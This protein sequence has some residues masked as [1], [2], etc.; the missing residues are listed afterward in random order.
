[1]CD[2]EEGIKSR[3]Q[4]EQRKAALS[5]LCHTQ[6]QYWTFS[7]N[8][9]QTMPPDRFFRTALLLLILLTC[10]ACSEQN[11][12]SDTSPPAPDVVTASFD[13]EALELPL[14]AQ[15]DRLAI[16]VSP[17]NADPDSLSWESL[18]PRVATIEAG[19]ITATGLGET[20]IR[21][22]NRDGIEL[23]SLE[24]TIRKTRIY[25]IGN[26]HTWDFAPSYDFRNLAAA[27]GVEIEN[28]WHIYCGHNIADILA[29]PENTCV[30]SRFGNFINALNSQQ[31]DIVTLQPF[32]GGTGQSE[33]NAIKQMIE[34]IE[35]NSTTLP[36][37]YIYYT[38]PYNGQSTLTDFDYAQAW[39]DPFNPG[40]RLNSLNGNFI[41]YLRTELE[42]DDYPISGYIP[43]GTI[44]EEFHHAAQAGQI[45]GFSGAGELYRDALHMNNVGRFLAGTT[46]FASLFG[47]DTLHPFNHAG[48]NPSPRWASD[49]LLSSE[50]RNML[51]EL[52]RRA[53][54]GS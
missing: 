48:Y 36:Q 31:W 28:D 26:S 25:S 45:T 9:P 39:Q 10:H 30:P 51:L 35:A 3:V 34:L 17:E 27:Q 52:M 53:L 43:V 14:T 40:A 38:W 4:K 18:D 24:V 41:A 47:M 13:S 54:D 15:P 12:S 7:T 33:A 1:M 32:T 46:V 29:S 50:Q 42:N 23:D 2:G 37:I 6:Q 49:R 21:I 16:S 22:R 20:T 44:L 19:V 8:L 5:C 11:A